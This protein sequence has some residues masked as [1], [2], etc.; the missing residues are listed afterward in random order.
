MT[1]GDLLAQLDAFKRRAGQRAGELV[2]DPAQWLARFGPEANDSFKDT[3]GDTQSV[4]PGVR[5]A[6]LD[7]LG[8]AMGAQG[9]EAS[10][11][12]GQLSGVQA[13][14]LPLLA[15]KGLEE[16][17]S[18]ATSRMLK[19]ADIPKKGMPDYVQKVIDKIPDTYGPLVRQNPEAGRAW[20]NQEPIF[21]GF[22]QENGPERGRDLFNFWNHAI[23][24][25][26]TK[27]KVPQNLKLASYYLNKYA[28]GKLGRGLEMDPFAEHMAIEP[29]YGHM[30]QSDVNEGLRDWFERGGFDS[31]TR[32]KKASFVEN[33][34]GNYDPG[35]ID[36][37]VSRAI[38]LTN[39]GGK[40]LDAPKLE[41]YGPIENAV[42]ATSEA[43]GLKS[44]QG[45]AAGWI[46]DPKL[47]PSMV[48]IVNMLLHRTADQTGQSPVLTLKNFLQGQQAFR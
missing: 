13:A 48:E 6:G 40:P 41:W 18:Y 43:H 9:D 22:M 47:D 46:K 3:V 17:P 32:P 2:N 10:L 21:Q 31:V 36:Q 16:L 25:T 39:K 27:Q 45:Q 29:G 8:R 1:L 5:E 28:T 11:T 30:F 33:L 12:L 37:R 26:T 35:T 23:G 14:G 4:M 42:K 19:R 38:G 15:A 44:A 7:A 24:A 34:G 20:F